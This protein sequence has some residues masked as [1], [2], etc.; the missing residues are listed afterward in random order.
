LIVGDIDQ[1][2]SVGPG[3]VLADMI[4]SETVPVVRLT[5][6]FRQAANSQIIINAHRINQGLFPATSV[7]ERKLTDF[8]FIQAETVEEVQEKLLTMVTERIPK[9]FNLDPK[10]DIQ[11]LTP[12]HRGGLGTS[13]LN[14]MLQE[15]LNPHGSP[16]INVLGTTFATGDK[17][18]QNV[19]NYNKNVFNGDIGIITYID[20]EE[21]EVRANFDGHI[22]TYDFNELYEVSLAYVT[23]I[24]KSQGSEYPA[25]V[26]PISIQ[27]YMLLARNLLYT[28]VTRGKKLVVLIGQTKALA[29]AVKN[30]SYGA[31]VTNLRTQLKNHF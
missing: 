10:R 18:I 14:T 6:I 16:K 13:S 29:M 2:P 26:I 12:M 17:I 4:S 1:L 20:L 28:A 9:Q 3:M 27:H 22:V 7:V 23:T 25:V 31:R 19:N 15:K 30:G 11:V 21:K 5:E 8:Y 24:H